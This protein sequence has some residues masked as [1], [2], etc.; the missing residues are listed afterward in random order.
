MKLLKTKPT[1]RH[2]KIISANAGQIKNSILKTDVL[3]NNQNQINDQ[4]KLAIINNIN[5]IDINNKN[6]DS[7]IGN[8]TQLDW[9]KSVIEV[10][11]K[12]NEIIKL[13]L[14]NDN[15]F[16]QQKIKD[17][18]IQKNK[19]DIK[20]QTQYAKN[21]NNKN[22]KKNNFDDDDY[23]MRKFAETTIKEKNS[24]LNRIDNNK[25]SANVMI[26]TKDSEKIENN[27]MQ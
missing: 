14:D 4:E 7:E 12:N 11:T 23:I 2:K 25:D 15:W 20:N 16:E 24:N 22:Y 6:N 8:M 19:I 5:E 21:K 1:I 13:S 18:K 9:V 10:K 27:Y 17:N 3:E 26:S